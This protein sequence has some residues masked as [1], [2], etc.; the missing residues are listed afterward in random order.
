MQ[1]K[2]IDYFNNLGDALDRLKELLDEP[3]DPKR[4][5][6]DAVI[7][8]YEFCIELMWKN[9]KNLLEFEQITGVASP[10]QV[11]IQ[12][13]AMEWISDQS[14]WLGM[15]E[16]RNLTSHTYKKVTADLVYKHIV[17][18]YPEMQKTYKLLEQRYFKSAPDN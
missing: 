15:L 8:R 9:M 11:F 10:K 12:A 4:A 7:H 13:Y 18:Y 6:M 16:D 14:L 3:I 1:Q 17:Q 5:M 2:Y